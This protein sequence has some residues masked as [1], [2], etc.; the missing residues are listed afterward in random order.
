MLKRLLGRLRRY[1]ITGLVVVAPVGVTVWI[2]TWL[3]Q[4]LDSILGRHLP[5]LGGYR[6]PGLGLLILVVLLI[7]V[8]WTLQ[9]AMGRKLV[10][11]G[12]SL[13]SRFPLTRRIYNAS[14]QIVQTVLSRQEKFFRSC[15]LAEY[16]NA[17]SYTLVF[18]T[19]RT[20]DEV[21]ER[22]GEPS[23]TVFLP[24][25]PNPTSG[26]L[27]MMPADRVQV[28]EMSV[29][30]GIKMVLSAGTVR[31]GERGAGL[32]GLDLERLAGL[33]GR[34]PGGEGRRGRRPWR[35]ARGDRPPAEEEGDAERGG[36]AGQDPG[37][38]AGDGPGGR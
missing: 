26:Y 12:N 8:G 20:P 28:L 35:R 32:A 21:E 11:W 27:M 23:V 9:W 14:S 19:A 37:P 3:F 33:S 25:V 31:P 29:E 2:L 34:E 1:L 7:A 22:I 6:L 4:R 38:D 5:T 18:I 30:D 15:A 24:T 13:L 10:G 17:G 16:P 36:D